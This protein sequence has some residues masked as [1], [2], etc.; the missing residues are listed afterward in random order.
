MMLRHFGRTLHWILTAAEAGDNCCLALVG[1]LMGWVV[2][3][4]QSGMLCC[5]FVPDD[6]VSI[7]DVYGLISASLH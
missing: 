4:V 2:I 1:I 7:L 6:E 3:S 5:F